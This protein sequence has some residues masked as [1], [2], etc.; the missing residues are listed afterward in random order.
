M[1]LTIPDYVAGAFW[2]CLA[3]GLSALGAIFY[4]IKSQRIPLT[5]GKKKMDAEYL[6][7]EQF[8]NKLRVHCVSQHTEF[9]AKLESIFSAQNRILDKI[10]A[11][12]ETQTDILQRVSKME[13]RFDTAYTADHK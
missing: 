4:S 11:M 1:V 13:G 12:R 9:H 2:G 3:A 6:T 5:W 8:D 7:A 10:D